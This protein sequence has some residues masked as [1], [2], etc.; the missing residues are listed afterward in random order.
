MPGTMLR[1]QTRTLPLLLLASFAIGC[2]STTP[3]PAA[4]ITMT[5]GSQTVTL[6]QG[7]SSTVMVTLARVAFTGSIS[8]A[9]TGLPSGVTATFAPASVPDGTTSSTM[10]LTAT[11]SAAAGTST[12][13]VTASGTGVTSKTATFGLTVS[14]AGSYSMTPSPASLTLTQGATATSTI[15]ITRTGGFAQDVSLAASGLPAGVTAAFNP[16]PVTGTSSVVTF[17][18]ASTATAGAA[19]VTITGTTPGLANQTTTVNLTVASQTAFSIDFCSNDIPLWFAYQN[20]GAAWTRVVP[21]AN[22]TVTFNGTAKVG[23]AFVHEPTAGSFSTQVIYLTAAEAQP[24]NGVACI[25]ELGSKTLNG[26][27]AGVATGQSASISMSFQGQFVAPPST[28][29]TLTNLPTGALDLVASRTTTPT[30]GTPAPDRLIV[31]RALDLASGATIPALDFGAA[32]AVAPATANLTVTGLVTGET[33]FASVSYMTNVNSATAVST[34]HFLWNAQLTG[35]TAAFYAAPASLTAAADLHSLSVNAGP[36]SGTE[37]RSASTYFKN[38][39]DKTVALG[40]S[41]SVPTFTQPGTTPYVRFRGQLAS[42]SEY[43]SMV[44]FD[45]TQPTRSATIEATAAYFGTTPTTWDLTIPDFSA[46]TGWSNTWGLQSAQAT[47]LTAFASAGESVVGRTPADGATT[48]S[49]MRMS[50]VT[51]TMSA[52][53]MPGQVSGDPSR[54]RGF[55]PLTQRLGFRPA[56]RME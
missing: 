46:V 21:D 19:A 30:G 18:A 2:S 14:V 15:N 32:E 28:T 33:N 5:L 38:S 10:T 20:E 34:H 22:G 1:S 12:V 31:R 47:D 7:Q 55:V 24:L 48:K 45:F 3:T 27:V 4:S 9:A 52:M 53:R 42:Q 8:L 26:S 51:S 17:T 44:V 54:F 16:S 25:D 39:A 13:T 11:S 50:K 35:S 56:G 6:T 23:V 36:T 29:F 41:L 49:A 37:F 40:A 43:G